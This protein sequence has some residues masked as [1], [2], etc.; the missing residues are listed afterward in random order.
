MPWAADQGT[1]AQAQAQARPPAHSV[2]TICQ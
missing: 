1:Q 2:V